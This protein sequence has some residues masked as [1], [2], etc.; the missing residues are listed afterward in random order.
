MSS[1]QNPQLEK[2]VKTVD[3]IA[4]EITA[5]K[6]SLKEL[7]II[8]KISDRVESIGKSVAI[9]DGLSTSKDLDALAKKIATMTKTM[10]DIA[11][12]LKEIK[13]SSDTAGV[14]SK[15]DK[16]ITELGEISSRL[17]KIEDSSGVDTVISKVDSMSSSIDSIES[18]VRSISESSDIDTL[19]KKIDDLQEYIANLSGIEE[20]ITDLS[21]SF[22]ETKEIVSIIVR[23]L[24][25]LERKYNR[26][27]EDIGKAIDAVTKLA[28][29]AP[30]PSHEPT[31]H[32]PEVT[33]PPTFEVGES[34]TI[35]ELMNELL[36]MVTP[37]TE[38]IKMAKAL[39]RVRDT[40]TMMLK[41]TTPV[42]FQ[43]GK[44]ARELK[45]YPPTATLNENDIARLNKEIREWRKKLLESA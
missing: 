24:D 2:I 36:A 44:R 39:E 8:P 18:T 1:E 31:T 12:L 27:L 40:L 3:K 22:E 13:A 16:A 38:A 43:F 37:R 32:V 6:T 41:G 25:D 15:V 30:A 29:A 21:T 19:I 23:Q 45:S 5:L 7:S 28:E 35:D 20:K 9:I 26:A 10:N 4:D 17:E 34:P 42:L 14:I 11:K 33:A